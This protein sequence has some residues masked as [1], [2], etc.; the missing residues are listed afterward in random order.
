MN[1]IFKTKRKIYKLFHPPYGEILMLHRVVEKRSLLEDNRSLEITPDFLEQTILRYKSAGYRFVSLDEVQRQLENRKRGRQKFV[2]FTLDDGYADNY[3]QAYPVFKKHQCPFAVY[4]TT[5]FPDKKASLWWYRLQDILLENNKLTLNG[6]E[7]CCTDLEKKNRTFR[8]IR[9][10]VFSSEAESTEKALEQLFQENAYTA[11]HDVNAL[12]MSWEQIAELAADPL[13][14][15]GAHTVSH[16]SLP[17]QTDEKIKEELSEG[18]KK[19]ED[20]IKKPVKHFAYPY[21]NCDRRTAGLVM[22]QYS[23]AVLANGGLVRKGD[24]ADKL[25][26]NILNSR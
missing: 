8:E 1:L 16:V 26:R 15:I 24:T 11:Q 23:T 5:D 20:R 2:C 10:R 12:A 22:E 6:A 18:K 19:I 9:D 7:Y 13:C 14:T 25:K 21:G 4:V 17:A 3:E